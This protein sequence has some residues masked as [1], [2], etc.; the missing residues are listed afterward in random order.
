MK[1]CPRDIL[2]VL[3]WLIIFAIVTIIKESIAFTIISIIFLIFFYIDK[4]KE[5]LY[6][7][8]ILVILDY[9]GYFYFG[10]TDNV[11]N[12]SGFK[13]SLT[14]L[15][16]IIAIIKYGFRRNGEKNL[17]LQPYKLYISYYVVLITIGIL[18]GL[19]LSGTSGRGYGVYASIITLFL[20]Y[21]LFLTMP[22]LYK[23][24]LYI[25]RTIEILNFIVIL[26]ILLQIY[27]IITGA[28]LASRF[29]G[30]GSVSTPEE[31]IR[32]VYGTYIC[33]ITLTFSI[34]KIGIRQGNIIWH[35]LIL[36]LSFGSIL[37]SATR[38]W[39]LAFLL[40]ILISWFI[41]S[42]LKIHELIK[43]TS[44][45]L[46]II[47]IFMQFN[48]INSQ[49]H[50]SMERLSTIELIFKGDPTAGG[51]NAR[52]TERHYPVMNKFYENPIFGW[53]FSAVGYNTYD[54]HVGNQSLL[55]VGGVIGYTIVIICLLWIIM[56]IYKS[57]REAI[58]NNIKQVYDVYIISFLSLFVIHS[59]STDLF[60]FMASAMGYH[61]KK[62]FFLAIY[63]SMLNSYINADKYCKKL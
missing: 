63:L 58:K 28:S 35:Y 47:L 53:G 19:K 2:L 34:Y 8:I 4:D 56:I 33:F 3:A 16:S 25:D 40:M 39:I 44:I 59:T 18:Q 31:L 54:V 6:P 45:I 61:Y 42:K 15:F 51:T 37:I 17:F 32:P 5:Y 21:P 46:I 62:L 26:N 14:E 7:L 60:S 23:N 9:P 48:V 24:K 49:V 20:L 22:K 50:K 29:G 36:V 38:G 12:I 13:L 27:H 52:L 57:K 1:S 55:M 30:F 11:L 10:L 43:N 41:I